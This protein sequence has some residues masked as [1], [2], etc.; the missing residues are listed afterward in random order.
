M[1]LT[2]KQLDKWIKWFMETYEKDCTK[3]ENG[4]WSIPIIYSENPWK[5]ELEHREMR[6]K[7][8]KKLM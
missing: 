5:T 8:L 6:R 4:K 7:K 2:D 1:I 3:D